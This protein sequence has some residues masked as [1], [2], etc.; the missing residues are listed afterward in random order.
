MLYYTLTIKDTDY[1]LRLGAKE[2]V[3][4]EKKLGTNPLNVFMKIAQTQELPSLEV[5][6]LMLHASLQKY[7]HGTT[8]EK[9]YDI[10]DEYTDEGHNLMDLVNVIMEVMKVSGLIPEEKEETDAKNAETVIKK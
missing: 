8:M 6:I 3:D 5:M 7:N 2:C 10:Y 4:L 1:K 9:V